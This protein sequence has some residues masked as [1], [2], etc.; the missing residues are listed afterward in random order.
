MSNSPQVRGVRDAARH[1]VNAELAKRRDEAVCD[2]DR[3]AAIQALVVENS[4]VC[5]MWARR[6]GSVLPNFEFDELVDV[7]CEQ[8]TV[9]ARTWDCDRGASFTTW[10]SFRIRSRL[11]HEV[12]KLYGRRLA[13]VALVVTQARMSLE[14]MSG[15]GVSVDEVA[16]KVGL[17][18]DRVAAVEREVAA[19]RTA[20]RT[21]SLDGGSYGGRSLHERV[22]YDAGPVAFSHGTV[23]RE[24]LETLS[25]RHRRIVE[26]LLRC[27]A[28]QV[29][30]MVAHVAAELDVPASDVEAEFAA[31]FATLSGTGC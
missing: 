5:R 19:V 28:K 22:A 23:H 15:R 12:G 10:A 17:R 30:E 21:R 4:G 13:K 3:A 8:L 16:A 18:A 20:A 24:V 26:M 6:Y 31:L 7:A 2:A 25:A 9:A 11:S 27:G 29:D 14:E 1:V